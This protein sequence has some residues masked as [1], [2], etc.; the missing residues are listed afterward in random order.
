MN[1]KLT[2]LIAS[3]NHLVEYVHTEPLFVKNYFSH[4]YNINNRFQIKKINK[5][6]FIY[7]LGQHII[8]NNNKIE[9]PNYVFT[10]HTSEPYHF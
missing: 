1:M 6:H 5:K 4:K 7:S 10:L 2:K 3:L 8:I 9:C